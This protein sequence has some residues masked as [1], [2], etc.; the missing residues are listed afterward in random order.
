MYDIARYDTKDGMATD[1]YPDGKSDR[2][3]AALAGQPIPDVEI[4]PECGQYI[5]MFM[6]MGRERL[7][8]PDGRTNPIPSSEIIAWLDRRCISLEPWE[9][10]MIDAMDA[11]FRRGISDHARAVEKRRSRDAKRQSKRR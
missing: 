2:T 3:R 6:Q 7:A 4:W 11:A 5:E 9:H 10:D 8:G 1:G